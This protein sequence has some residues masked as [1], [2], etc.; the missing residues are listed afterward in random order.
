MWHLPHLGQCSIWQYAGCKSTSLVILLGDFLTPLLYCFCLAMDKKLRFQ[1]AL[2]S[3]TPWAWGCAVRLY[4]WST[5]ASENFLPL[6]FPPT[7]YST[8]LNLQEPLE[9]G[10]QELYICNNIFPLLFY[11][12]YSIAVSL[13]DKSTFIS[14]PP[15]LTPAL[16]NPLT[17]LI[18]PVLLPVISSDSPKSTLLFGHM[19][20]IWNRWHFSLGF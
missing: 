17:S 15:W 20:G 2:S 5:I 19:Q 3:Q 11:F 4:H 14:S 6:P 12:T 13:D 1:R 18:D 8:A 9:K 7:Y 16:P 10:V